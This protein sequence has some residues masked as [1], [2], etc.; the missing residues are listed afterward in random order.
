MAWSHLT[1]LLSAAAAATAIVTPPIQLP[2]ISSP[3]S[4]AARILTH[5]EH[6]EHSLTITSHI[7]H[8]LFR[9][10][11]DGEAPTLG[12]ICPGATAGYTGYLNSNEKHFY[13]SY[14]ESRSKP[15]EDPVVL[16]LNGGPGCSSMTGEYTKA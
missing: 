2:L 15:E 6:P 5:P 8:D 14:F 7:A 12:D 10:K 3:D 11:K 1:L 13:F 16:W 4:P 9:V